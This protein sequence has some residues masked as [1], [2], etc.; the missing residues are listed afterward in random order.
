MLWVHCWRR[1]DVTHQSYSVF[2]PNPTA[3]KNVKGTN[4]AG[5]IGVKALANSKFVTLVWRALAFS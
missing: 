3:V 4:V 2:K 1:I 5:L